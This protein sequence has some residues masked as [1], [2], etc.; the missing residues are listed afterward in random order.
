MERYIGGRRGVVGEWGLLD[1]G[2]EK[3]RTGRGLGGVFRPREEAELEP[4]SEEMT[5]AFLDRSARVGPE[6]G[7][8]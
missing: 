1:L 3:V 8:G 7:V 4:E 6:I 5:E 2:E